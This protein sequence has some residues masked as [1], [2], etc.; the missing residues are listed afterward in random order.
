LFATLRLAFLP[1]YAIPFTNITALLAP[2]AEAGSGFP[3]GASATVTPAFH[4][5]RMLNVT[6]D[7]LQIRYSWRTETGRSLS[8]SFSASRTLLEESERSFGFVRAEL[9]AEILKLEARLRQSERLSPMAK[10]LELVSRSPYA[11]SVEAREGPSGEIEF[12]VAPNG[13]P[14]P[15]LEAELERLRSRLDAE[16]IP[17][18]E[19]IRRSIR[20]YMADYL[21][22]RGLVRLDT[23]VGVRYDDM[24]RR[25]QPILKPLADGLR[26]HAGRQ[27]RGGEL[28]T[29]L[30]FIQAIPSRGIPME[31]NGRYV[32]G[33]SVPLSVLAEDVGDCDSKAVLFASIWRNLH[34]RPLALIRMPNHMIVGVAARCSEGEGASIVRNSVRYLLC[35]VCPATPAS[36]GSLTAYS[37]ECLRKG[38]FKATFLR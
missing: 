20:K 11:G 7:G 38:L 33:F 29:V 26:N 35:E 32:A 5:V 3:S 8:V 15:G 6:A 19:E 23:G 27:D 24:V 22:R 14:Q 9:L 2:Q 21:E 13:T 30:S 31:K 36:P 4:R 1:F 18:R 12:A 17:C 25:Y 28:E 37:A 16:W 10:A 34:K